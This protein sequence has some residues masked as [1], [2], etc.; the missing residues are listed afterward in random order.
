[1]SRLSPAASLRLPGVWVGFAGSLLIGAG[2]F[3]TSFSHNP[4]GWAT[5]WATQVGDAL[6]RPVA[7]WLILLGLIALCLGWWLLR[8]AGAPG[9][10]HALTVGALWSAPL[11]IVPPVLSADPFL[12]ADLGWIMKW[13][14][15]PYAVGLTGAGGPYAP[16]V[17]D[18]WAGNGVA[19]PPLSLEVNRIAIELVGAHPYWGVIAQ[20]VPALIG[21]ALVMWSLPRLAAVV[22]VEAGRAEWLGVLN[23]L[24][25]VHFVGGAHND[26]LM[27]GVVMLALWLATRRIRFVSAS[28][29]L[30]PVVVG[31]AMGLKQ[32]SG[33]A[34]IA[35]AG[36]PILAPLARLPLAQRVAVLG[37]RSAVGGV[38]ALAT[39]VVTS[40][41][42]GL[43]FGWVDWMS[44][45][46][47]ARTMTLGILISDLFG[48]GPEVTAAA[49]LA[50]GLLSAAALAVLLIRRSDRPVTIVAWGSLLVLFLSQALHPWYL[51]LTLV[52]LALVPLR[53][54]TQAWVIWVLFG[55]LIAYAI[56][57]LFFVPGLPAVGL[58]ALIALVLFGATRAARVGAG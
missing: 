26:A 57:F 24:L 5:R 12:Y 54:T 20:R 9:R 48:G 13:G 30:A 23:P 51:G 58:G 47:R 46:S 49:F 1:M 19:Y 37:W 11:L 8:P 31:L 40:L 33:L 14:V 36:L 3:S 55:Y 50:V 34:V 41:A 35:T 22:G 45:M 21:V 18:F 7:S 44:Q 43:G 53:R 2:A 17:D 4:D 38:I 52:L 27:T 29:V 39:F 10:P 16:W 15:D 42:T 32:Q 25:I 6:S 28:L 56:Q